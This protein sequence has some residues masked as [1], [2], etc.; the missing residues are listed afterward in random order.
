MTGIYEFDPV[1]YP[2]KVW[3]ARRGVTL[4]QI[5][6]VF[7][8]LCEDDTGIPFKGNHTLPT[9]GT[10]A[11][12]FIVGHKKQGI[13]GCLVVFGHGTLIKDLSHEADHCADW[14]FER[15]GETE[16]D[17]ERGECYAY[18]QSWVFECLYKVFKG[19]L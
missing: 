8:A 18:Y 5:D 12:T 17:Y 11:Q 3:V 1:I 4:E 16:R 19:K 13:T 14:L 10:A 2:F 15:I 7:E 9:I 6:K